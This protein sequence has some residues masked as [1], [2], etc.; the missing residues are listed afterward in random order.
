MLDRSHNSDENHGLD[1]VA[2]M[3]GELDSRASEAFESHLENCDECAVELGAFAD[4]RLGVIE[5]RRNDFEHLAT[6]AIII[7]ETERVTPVRRIEKIGVFAGFLESIS[8]L[9]AY[10]SAGF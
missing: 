4:A 3:Y 9:S 5:W 1:L 8:S 7:P 2:Y 10:A 6:P